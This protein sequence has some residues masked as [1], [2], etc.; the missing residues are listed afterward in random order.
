MYRGLKSSCTTLLPL[1]SGRVEVGV[2]RRVLPLLP[3]CVLQDQ[4]QGILL[5]DGSGD[6]LEEGG[7][8]CIEIVES[9]TSYILYWGGGYRCMR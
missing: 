1:R 4:L 2:L 5:D 3:R 9:K 8:G 7:S 6:V